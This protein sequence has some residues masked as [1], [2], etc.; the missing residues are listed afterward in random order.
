MKSSDP[1]DRR[2]SLSIG[3]LAERF[4]LAPHVLRHWESRGLLT[5]ARDPAGRRRYGA[6]DLTRVTVILRGKQA[7]LPL[8]AIRALVAEPAARRDVLGAQAERLRAE[9]AAAQDALALVEC[10][11]GCDHPDVTRCAHVRRPPGAT[12]PAPGQ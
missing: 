1:S 11:L 6:A 8:D 3:A 7:G 12:E 10:A 4:G 5:P 9:I 2:A